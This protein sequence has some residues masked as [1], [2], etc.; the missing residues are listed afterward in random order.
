MMKRVQWQW[1]RW[2]LYSVKTSR[3]SVKNFT[4]RSQTKRKSLLKKNDI[5]TKFPLWEQRWTQSTSI[6]KAWRP[7]WMNIQD[8]LRETTPESHTFD[9]QWPQSLPIQALAK[10]IIPRSILVHH[11]HHYC[12]QRKR[13]R[14]HFWI[15][16]LILRICRCISQKSTLV[17]MQHPRLPRTDHGQLSEIIE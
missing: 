1:G 12:T 9:G 17:D 11:K 6:Q 3:M 15:Q 2:W 5:Q 4:T 7:I 16:K 13:N 8:S 10:I 14:H